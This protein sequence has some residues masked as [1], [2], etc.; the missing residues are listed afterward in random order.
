MVTGPRLWAALGEQLAWLAGL[1]LAGEWTYR[2]GRR[3]L[4]LQGG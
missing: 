3:R 4:T 1:A 2:L